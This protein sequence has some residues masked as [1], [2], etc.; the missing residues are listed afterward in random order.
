MGNITSRGGVI[1]KDTI[2]IT[3]HI[4]DVLQVD[5]TL[6]ESQARQVLYL[7]KHN[8]DGTVGINWD[9]IE[10]TIEEVK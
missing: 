10:Q 9:V 7:L 8:H 1:M 5:D 3:W 2:S 4:D 6:T